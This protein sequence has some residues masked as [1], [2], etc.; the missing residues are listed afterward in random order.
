MT[1][2]L[3]TLS[4]AVD[5]DNKELAKLVQ[6]IGDEK[7]KLEELSGTASSAKQDLIKLKADVSSVSSGKMDKE[8]MELILKKHQQN[9][10]MTLGQTARE[11]DAKI[12]YLQRKVKELDRI[13][14]LSVNEKKAAP[15]KTEPS[16]P[17]NLSSRAQKRQQRNPHPWNRVKLSNRIFGNKA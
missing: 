15:Q 9:F 5:K 10:K 4:T 13:S 3:V 16:T 2:D 12:E 8:L 14:Q 7:R 6:T 17:Q 1:Q 11:I